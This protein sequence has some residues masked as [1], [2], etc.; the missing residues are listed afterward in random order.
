MKRSALVPAVCGLLLASAL[1]VAP[2]DAGPIVLDESMHHLGDDRTPDWTEAPEEPSA[3][4]SLTFEA[5]RHEG[6][7]VL[8]LEQRSVDDPLARRDQ[9]RARGDPR[10]LRGARGA[11]LRAPARVPGRGHEH[12]R[13]RGRAR[14][15]RPDRRHHR[16]PRAP[17]VR[18][19]ARGLRPA[20]GARARRGR[21]HGRAAARRG[22]PS[23]TRRTSPSACSTATRPRP[24][25]AGASSTPAT[26]RRASSC[27]RVR[28]GSTPRAAW[29]GAWAARSC[30]STVPCTRCGSP[31]AGRSTRRASWP[32][33]PTCTR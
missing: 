28:T 7:C 4:W 14:A 17:V 29:S 22:S 26:G 33:T 27:R 8:A 19:P 18:H 20:P 11:L 5:R 10:D 31:C 21:R 12:L 30:A 3:S 24:P 13:P 9:R 25:C 2:Q 1:A 23:P 15:R 32:A 16:R 6:A